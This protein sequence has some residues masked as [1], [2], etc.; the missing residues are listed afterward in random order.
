MLG[1]ALLFSAS[2]AE[3]GTE[4]WRSDGTAAGTRQVEAA[5]ANL[6]ELAQAL[7]ALAERYRH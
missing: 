2:D 3:G 5:S 4:L 7:M 1:D 6:T